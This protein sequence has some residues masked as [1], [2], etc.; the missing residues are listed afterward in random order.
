MNDRSRS[1]IEET[2]L[3]L[4]RGVGPGKTVCPSEVARA[5]AG[6]DEKVWRLLMPPIRAAAVDLAL[7]GVVEIRRKGRLVDPKPGEVWLLV[8]SAFHMPRSMALFRKAGFDVT[9]WPADYRT[10]GDEGFGFARDNPLDGLQMM[11]LAIRE[12]A[13]LIAYYLTGRIDRLFPSPRD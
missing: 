3:S 5:I 6:K 13:G 12:W 9:P 11:S 4:A 10:A 8:T 7:A 1:T 2:M